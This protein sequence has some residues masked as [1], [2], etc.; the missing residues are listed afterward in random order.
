MWQS[1]DGEELGVGVGGEC[2]V[3]NMA[4]SYNY[5]IVLTLTIDNR[6]VGVCCQKALLFHAHLLSDVCGLFN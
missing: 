5:V 3:L 4:C 6:I 1:A 2:G